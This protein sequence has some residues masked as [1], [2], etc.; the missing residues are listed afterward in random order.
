ML[1]K[2]S[3]FDYSLCSKYPGN[4]AFRNLILTLH[5]KGYLYVKKYFSFNRNNFPYR[6]K[7]KVELGCAYHNLRAQ[8]HPLR[9]RKAYFDK[10]KRLNDTGHTTTI[11]M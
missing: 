10:F 2:V 7:R 3:S 1:L 9:G 11:N 5:S 6:T 4:F 8:V